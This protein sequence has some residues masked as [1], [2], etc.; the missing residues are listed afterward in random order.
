M[1]SY[2]RNRGPLGTKQ[3]PSSRTKFL[4]CTVARAATSALNSSLLCSS[5]SMRFTAIAVP[6][7]RIPLK[8]NVRRG[9]PSLSRS[10]A[11]EQM[12]DKQP[13]LSP[14]LPP[15]LPPSLSL[16]PSSVVCFFFRVLPSFFVP[17][18]VGFSPCLL[19]QFATRVHHLL[20]FETNYRFREYRE[21]N[22]PTTCLPVMM[23][24]PTWIPRPRGRPR[25]HTQHPLGLM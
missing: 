11:H 18:S 2:T 9:Y 21:R 7:S 20:V 13:S 12:E 15:S 22:S 19:D 25:Q 24:R 23:W 1:N 5:P 4:C 16:P 17:S 14:A 10:L 3:N 6:S 8:T